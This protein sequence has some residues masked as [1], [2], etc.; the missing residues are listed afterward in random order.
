MPE[1]SRSRLGWRTRG[2]TEWANAGVRLAR[3]GASAMGRSDYGHTQ[4]LVLSGR[5]RTMRGCEDAR[6]RE[7]AM[8][9]LINGAMDGWISDS[10]VATG[11]VGRFR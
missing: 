7:I 6:M 3:E 10:E 5:K 2:L 11:L 8:R 9:A 4:D 1:E